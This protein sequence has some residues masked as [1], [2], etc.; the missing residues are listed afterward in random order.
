[1][2]R[3]EARAKVRAVRIRPGLI[4]GIALDDLDAEA[5][6]IIAALGVEVESDEVEV[7]LPERLDTLWTS[8]EENLYRLRGGTAQSTGVGA[9]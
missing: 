4:A 3:S 5:D 6:A 8:N 2:K 1:M 9:P 7:E